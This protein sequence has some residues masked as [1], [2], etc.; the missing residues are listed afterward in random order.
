MSSI[1]GIKDWPPG[2]IMVFDNRAAARQVN[3]PEEAHV[4]FGAV[5][6]NDGLGTIWVLWD[7]SCRDRFVS[8]L[9]KSLNHQV[10]SRHE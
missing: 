8:Y 6:A 5:V 10:I 9:V 3:L 7:E 4:G 1:N 2:T